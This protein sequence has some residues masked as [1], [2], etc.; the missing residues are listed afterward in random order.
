[1][2]KTIIDT[3]NLKLRPFDA[4]AIVGFLIIPQFLLTGLAKIT[5]QNHSAAWISLFLSF[6]LMICLFLIISALM[7]QYE[8]KN[9]VEIS[10]L[11]IG[12]PLSI[13]YGSILTV[14]FCYFTGV[15]IRETTEILKAYGFY[16]TPT[17]V[18]LGLIVLAAVTM[19]FFGAKSIIKTVGFFYILALIGIVFV[20]LLGSNQYNPDNLAP[21]LGSGV[22]TIVKSSLLG[23]SMFD[24]VFFLLLFAP[25]FQSS[26]NLK[27]SGLL[28]LILTGITTVLLCLCYIMM[29]SSD[30]GAEIISGFMEMGKSSYYNHFFYRFESVLLFFLIFSAL[31]LAAI[32]LLT[33]KK[34]V[35]ATFNIKSTKT[36][37]ILCCIPI[38]TA[39]I[40]PQNL[41][42]LTNNYLPVIKQ[43]SV[44]FVAG[45]PILI[46]IISGIKRIFKYEK[47]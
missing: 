40:I 7:K 23:T 21:V 22:K 9:I 24:G 41:Q 25:A 14:Y 10:S 17:Y 30:L 46:F 44:I 31:M 43:Y 34:C 4:A 2:I 32:G 20:I 47:F 3:D 45:I 13:I 29:F 42:E 12:K 33:V 37:I 39:A 36:L 16:L 28:S 1:M 27:K 15:Q 8:S 5:K 38:I 26:K 6:A 18:I 11:L 19:N 35:T